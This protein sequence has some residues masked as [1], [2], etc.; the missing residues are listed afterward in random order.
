MN[1]HVLQILTVLLGL[2]LIAV[3]ARKG[4]QAHETPAVV[5]SQPQGP[6]PLPSSVRLALGKAHDRPERFRPGFELAENKSKFPV[7]AHPRRI[8]ENGYDKVVGDDG[9]FARNRANGAT[10]GVPNANAPTLRR[11]AMT[12]DGNLHNDRVLDYFTHA[13]LPRD[14]VKSV[15]VSTLMETS[16]N[17]T[18]TIQ[19]KPDFKAFHSGI[20]RSVD[21]IAVVDSL[22]WA[23]FDAHDEAVEETAY[24]PPVPES[25]VQ[26]AHSL[27]RILGS[28]ASREA[29]LAKL[30]TPAKDDGHVVIRHSSYTLSEA[31]QF[32]A[33]Y[34]VTEGR[35]SGST[36]VRHFDVDGNEFNLPQE[37]ARGTS[38]PKKD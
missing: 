9:V 12:R 1:R 20:Q 22:A 32:F 18:D 8:V 2:T 25:V 35:G 24:W 15:R 5:S 36:V 37:L 14:Q 26:T 23:R 7:G 29:Y 16:G 28:A 31:P 33:S 17:A 19:R 38:D 13:G 3:L 21:G 10:L 27:E 30:Q 6:Q 34:D 11:A 4:L